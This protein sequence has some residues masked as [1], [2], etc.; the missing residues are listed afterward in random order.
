MYRSAIYD[1]PLLIELEGKIKG[2]PEKVL[3]LSLQRKEKV[4]IP[5]LDE[6]QIVRHFLRLSQMNYGIDEVAARYA[7]EYEI[8]KETIKPIIEKVWL[9]GKK[10]GVL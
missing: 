4:N 7:Y 9:N 3:P 5:D 1:E 2:K 10:E 8:D 6:T